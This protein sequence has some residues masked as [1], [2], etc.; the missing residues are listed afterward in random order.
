MRE[1]FFIIVPH[2]DG[3]M[4]WKAL[5]VGRFTT[6]QLLGLHV[7]MQEKLEKVPIGDPL[8]CCFY[9]KKSFQDKHLGSLIF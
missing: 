1:I 4:E 5:T 3:L 9:R 6:G 7:H 2:F 8:P